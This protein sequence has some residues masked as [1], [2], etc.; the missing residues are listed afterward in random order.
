MNKELKK[1]L[2][3]ILLF[4]VLLAV[5]LLLTSCTVNWFGQ[6]VET[7]WYTVAIPVAL[8]FVAAYWILMS[9]VYICPVCKTEFKPKWY[10][11]SV[12]LHFMGKRY[13]KCPVCGRKGFCDVKK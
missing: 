1:I 6:T 8:I 11:L 7:P 3:K 4:S 2:K 9:K 5:V 13:A 12:C 10:Q